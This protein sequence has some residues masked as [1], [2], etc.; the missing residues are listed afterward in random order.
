MMEILKDRRKEEFVREQ[1]KVEQTLLDELSIQ[2]RG[3]K[4][5]ERKRIEGES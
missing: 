1:D 3:R 2:D 5:G 4:D